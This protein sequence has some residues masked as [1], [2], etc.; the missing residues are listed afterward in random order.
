MTSP[1]YI[2]LYVDNPT[3]S[4][5]FYAHLL[6][7]SPVHNSPTFSLFALD[8]GLKFGLWAKHEVEPTT[9]MSGGG[10]ELVFSVADRDAVDAM[11]ADWA[12]RGIIIA[13]T[14]TVMDFGYTFTAVDPDGHRLR[15]CSLS[16]A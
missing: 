9:G 11:H 15:V 2:I 7:K 16:A 3:V 6:E 14:P 12:R 13:Q 8:S 5:H 10:S 1:N 4:T